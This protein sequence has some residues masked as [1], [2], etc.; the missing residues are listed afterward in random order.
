[1]C[2]YQILK[3]VLALAL[4]LAM[5]SVLESVM[6]LRQLLLVVVSV[7]VVMELVVRQLLLVVVVVLEEMAWREM[8]MGLVTEV[9]CRQ[10]L[11]LVMEVPRHRW[12]PCSDPEA[13]S[14]N[15]EFAKAGFVV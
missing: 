12:H 9:K 4:V 1:M 7:V 10:L 3:P 6:E 13:W 5:D 8:A 14:V 15:H 2:S 11:E